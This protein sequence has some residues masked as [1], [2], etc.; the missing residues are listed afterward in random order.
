MNVKIKGE[1]KI[2]FYSFNFYLEK[3]GKATLL[4]LHL[5]YSYQ[6]THLILRQT[7]EKQAMNSADC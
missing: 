3:D 6:C 1:N 4:A 7:T 2:K 5:N